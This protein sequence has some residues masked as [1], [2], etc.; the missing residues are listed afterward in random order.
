MK[1]NALILGSFCSG[2][3]YLII[4]ILVYLTPLSE[5][6]AFANTLVAAILTLSS[7]G[8]IIISLYLIFKKS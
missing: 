5:R 7:L 3:F 4:A 6:T 1:K 2:V 8:C